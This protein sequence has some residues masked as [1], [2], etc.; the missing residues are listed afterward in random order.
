MRA[1]LN[2][3]DEIRKN[4]KKVDNDVYHNIAVVKLRKAVQFA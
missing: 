1:A 2:S 4:S 3:Y